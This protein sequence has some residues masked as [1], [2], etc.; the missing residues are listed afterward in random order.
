VGYTAGVQ[1]AVKFGP[2]TLFADLR[3]AGDFGAVT[4]NNDEKTTYRRNMVSFSLGYEVGV[5][6]RKK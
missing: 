5:L 6:Y 3:Y 2:G 4:V 1:G